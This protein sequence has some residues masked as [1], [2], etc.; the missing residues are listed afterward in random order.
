MGFRSE[1]ELAILLVVMVCFMA[2]QTLFIF[3][4]DH[5]V[6][7]IKQEQSKL[8]KELDGMVFDGAYR[9]KHKPKLYVA[10]KTEKICEFKM[11]D[12]VAEASDGVGYD[13]ELMCS[14][15]TAEGGTDKEVC[16]AVAQCLMNTCEKHDWKYDPTEMMEMYRY[17]APADWVSDEARDACVEVFLNGGTYSAVGDATLFYAPRYCNSEWHEQQEFVCEVNGVRFFKEN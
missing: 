1:K 3:H 17:A 8:H 15:I 13:F 10:D 5:R 4:V 6:D 16:L 9:V 14:V 12:N 11:P 7:V 2:V